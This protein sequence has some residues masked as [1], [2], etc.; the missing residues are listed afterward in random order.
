MDDDLRA[1]AGVRVFE[2]SIAVA[3]PSCGRVLA[4]HGAEVIKVE[5]RVNADLARM[6]GSAW[7]RTEELAPVYYD[8]GPY[9]PEMSAGKLSLGL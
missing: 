2:L 4:Y 1:L 9:L 5:S 3:A 8:T 6:F 7:A